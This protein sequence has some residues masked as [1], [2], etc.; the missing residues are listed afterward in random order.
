M[1]MQT[2][3]AWNLHRNSK[4][5]TGAYPEGYLRNVDR[6]IGLTGKKVLHLFG[7]ITKTDE[8]NHTND[9]SKD[10]PST[11][12]FDVRKV[13]PIED[14]TYD[15]VMCDPPYDMDKVHVCSK[16]GKEIRE[17]I[18]YG[19]GLYNTE[20]VPPYSFMKEAVRVCKP[21]GFICV[22]HFLVYKKPDGAERYALIPIISGPNLRI[23][24]LSIFQK[25]NNG[26]DGIPPKP[27]V[28]GILPTI[29]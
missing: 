21:E 22:L 6:F 16:R 13:F 24:A 5:Y 3:E 29:I 27:K 10:L 4:S 2:K 25:L 18:H 26:N 17:K 1:A 12:K 14:N 19:K 20:F 28:L 7:G 23:R 9:I 11:F 8:N 15:V